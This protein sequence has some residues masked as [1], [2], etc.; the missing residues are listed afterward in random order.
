MRECEELGRR[1]QYLRYNVYCN[2][3]LKSRLCAKWIEVVPPLPSVP[4]SE[5]TNHLAIEII[6]RHPDLFIVNTPIQV[7]N[8]EGLL[9]NHPNRPFCSVGSQWAMQ[10]FLPMG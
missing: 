7:D 9:T 1:P 2:D 10:R 5:F 6:E 8:F 3:E 4:L